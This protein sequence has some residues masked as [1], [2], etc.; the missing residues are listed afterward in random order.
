VKK[1]NE[2]N[3]SVDSVKSAPSQAITI[4]Q[5]IR[6]EIM[7]T[8][9][10]YKLVPE[11]EE[12]E[13]KRD[14]TLDLTKAQWK[15][16]QYDLNAVEAGM[17]VKEES[18]GKGDI[19]VLTVGGEMVDNSKLKK[20]ILSRGPAQMYG[21]RDEALTTADSYTTASVLKAGI[22][23]IGDVDLVLCGEGSGDIYAQQVGAV[24]GALLGWPTVN[25]VSKI[26]PGYGKITVERSLEDGVEVLE[27]DLP[28]V[29]CVTTDINIPRIP[30]MKDILGAGKK[31]FTIWS[32]AEVGAEVVSGS[33]T[34]STLAPDQTARLKII[35]EGGSEESIDVLYN[36][37][38][39]L[40]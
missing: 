1:I 22:E 36:H 17:K 27:V 29:A 30:T 24:L 20:A 40:V 28:A 16:G 21:I 11:E 23:K 19:V 15:I 9:V 26:T 39:K 35:I 37:M 32:L 13:V 3:F 14:W 31:P 6:G 4:I 7:K 34:I 5:K 18:G 2:R 12:I 33:E 10:C 25:A 8:L 38:R